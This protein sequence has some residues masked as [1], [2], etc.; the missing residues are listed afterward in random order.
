MNPK[1]KA[2]AIILSHVAQMPPGKSIDLAA[3]ERLTGMPEALIFRIIA[4]HNLAKAAS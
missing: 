3:L 2:E 4:K 1:T